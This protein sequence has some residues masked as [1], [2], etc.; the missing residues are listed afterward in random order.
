[1]PEV[2]EGPVELAGYRLG[3]VA[4]RYPAASDPAL[5]G[6]SLDFDEAVFTAVIGPNGAGKSTLVRLLGGILTPTEGSI[7]LGGRPLGAWDR[8]ELARHTAVVSQDAP[9]K[10]FGSAC[11]RTSNW[12]GTRM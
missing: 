3:D 4:F 9:P 2:G 8:T 12:A 10:R 11:A 6:L 1:M 7:R 5:K